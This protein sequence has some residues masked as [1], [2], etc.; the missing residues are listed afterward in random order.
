VFG[1]ITCCYTFHAITPCVVTPFSDHMMISMFVTPNVV[2]CCY[3]MCRNTIFRPHDRFP[4]CYHHFSLHVV[5]LFYDKLADLHAATP[6]STIPAKIYVDTPTAIIPFGYFLCCFT[7]LLY[8]F[9][10]LYIRQHSC[11]VKISAIFH[12]YCML[13]LFQKGS[14]HHYLTPH[15]HSL[16]VVQ[17]QKGLHLCSTCHII[18]SH[19]P[20]PSL[21]ITTIPRGSNGGWIVQLLRQ[22]SSC[23]KL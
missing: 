20:E 23:G 8:H 21:I 2:P 1:R 17:P 4:C 14:L 18:I 22:I 5:T 11:F 9:C 12:N 10:H 13:S 16:P 6:N 7:H 19:V 15:L 3:T